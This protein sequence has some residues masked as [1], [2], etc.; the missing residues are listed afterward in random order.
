[1]QRPEI[2]TVRVYSRDKANRQTFAE[3]Y[4]KAFVDVY[5]EPIRAFMRLAN[6]VAR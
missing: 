1:M 6:S 5:G 2:S 3:K 4:S